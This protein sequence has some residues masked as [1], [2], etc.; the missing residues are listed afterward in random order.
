MRP[1]VLDSSVLVAFCDPDDRRHHHASQ[2]VTR[3]LQAGH[4]L[5]VPGS[6]LSE[7]LVGAYRSTPHAARTVEKLVGELV[8]DVR[9]I[10]HEVAKAAAR[11]RAGHADMSLGAALVLGTAKVVSAA[12]VMTADSSWPDVGLLVHVLGSTTRRE[13]D[14]DVEDPR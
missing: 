13:Q 6:A 2:D 7:V 9:P 12:R 1:V 5:V 10:D 14:H 4:P 11:Y 8:S 3:A